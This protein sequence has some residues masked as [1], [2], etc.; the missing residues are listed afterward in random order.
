MN[1]LDMETKDIV[2]NNIEKIKE[3]FPNIVSE[4]GIDFELLKQELSSAVIDEMSELSPA[5]ADTARADESKRLANFLPSLK[6]IELLTIE[7]TLLHKN[8]FLLW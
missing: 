7:I 6:R 2:N 3:L 5:K 4:D 8:L 1:K